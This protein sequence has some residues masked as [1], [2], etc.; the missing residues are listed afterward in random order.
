MITTVCITLGETDHMTQYH[1]TQ[2][3]IKYTTIKFPTLTPAVATVCVISNKLPF[4]TL[5]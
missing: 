4:D 2:T 3:H 5:M 1:S